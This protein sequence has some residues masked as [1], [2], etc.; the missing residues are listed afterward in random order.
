MANTAA[1]QNEAGTPDAVAEA[2]YAEASLNYA[3]AHE[4]Q[5]GSGSPNPGLRAVD[6]HGYHGAATLS[7]AT[8]VPHHCA[9]KCKSCSYALQAL[10]QRLR[11]CL[12]LAQEC[13]SVELLGPCCQLSWTCDANGRQSE[14]TGYSWRTLRRSRSP[15]IVTRQGRQGSRGGGRL[16]ALADC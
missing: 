12:Q 4:E 7:C 3:I 2:T 8:L 6:S 1:A 5:Q 14:P 16:L 13:Q 9:R 15:G 11:A 10:L